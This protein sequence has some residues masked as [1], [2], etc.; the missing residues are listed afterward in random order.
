[1][2]ATVSL[3]QASGEILLDAPWEGQSALRVHFGRNSV[4][5]PKAMLP[6]PG[7]ACT[8]TLG[9][10]KVT[11]KLVALEVTAG[12]R[13]GLIERMVNAQKG[14]VR[15]KEPLAAPTSSN[16]AAA[17]P[18]AA[19]ASTSADRF[20][21]PAAE[22][23][24]AAGCSRRRGCSRCRGVSRRGSPAAAAPQSGEFGHRVGADVAYQISVAD[25]NALPADAERDLSGF[26]AK[27]VGEYSWDNALVPPR[28]RWAAGRARCPSRPAPARSSSTRCGRQG[29][30]RN[31]R[32]DRRLGIN[33]KTGEVSARSIRVTKEAP[34][35]AERQLWV[36]REPAER[37]N[38]IRYAKGPDGTRGF[39]VGRGRPLGDA[40]GGGG[41]TT[42]I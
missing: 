35:A 21:S 12:V 22:A 40:G 28:R 31:G 5:S 17:A 1:M 19:P 38:V 9:R 18:A 32:R 27:S 24:R 29:G 2:V 39:T 10:H 25:P 15:L 41:D 36:K 7:T 37:T 14:I 30:F 42:A 16:S 11:K 8:F 26:K 23:A 3:A 20:A 6:P 13:A 33:P 34:K 4:A